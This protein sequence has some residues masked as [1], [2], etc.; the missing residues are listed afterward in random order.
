LYFIP[1]LR[2]VPA[3]KKISKKSDILTEIKKPEDIGALYDI[4]GRYFFSEDRSLVPIPDL[5]EVQKTSY[6][7]FTDEFIDLAMKEVFPILDFSEEKVEIHYKGFEFDE[8]KYT[9]EECKRKN[10]NYE[11]SIKVKL[12]ML[13]KETGEIKEDTVY[14]GGVPLMTKM[15]TFIVN[16]IERVIVSQIIKSDGLFFEPA[17]LAGV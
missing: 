9:A 15:G 1:N 10:L 8:P 6:K 14:V 11:S 12:E 17:K 16:G 5:I 3:A 4:K 13:N 7:K 2:T